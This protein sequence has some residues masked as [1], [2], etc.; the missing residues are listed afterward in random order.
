MCLGSNANDCGVIKY[1]SGSLELILI[2]ECELLGVHTHTHT[3][4]YMNLPY[5]HDWNVREVV[6]I[7]CMRSCL[8]NVV[9]I[10]VLAIVVDVL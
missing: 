10:P 3:H 8:G 9:I 4:M 2:H 7:V 6:R 1:I 5:P